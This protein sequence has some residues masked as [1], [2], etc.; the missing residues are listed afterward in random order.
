MIPET[1]VPGSEYLSFPWEMNHSMQQKYYYISNSTV[2]TRYGI[3]T[4]IDSSDVI[5]SLLPVVNLL[6]QKKFILSYW[7][8]E[9]DIDFKNLFI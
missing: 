5:F 7:H 2:A 8:S 9:R 3:R 4:Q 6:E 1:H